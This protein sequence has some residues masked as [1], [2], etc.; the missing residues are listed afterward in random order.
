M[1]ELSKALSDIRR[2]RQQVAESTEFRGYGPA[3]VAGTGLLAAIAA[4]GQSKWLPDPGG[5]H[6]AF[7]GL[8]IGTAA[9][10]VAL[11]S[12]EMY[13]R[14][15]RMQSGMADAMIRT[16]AE[17]FLPAVAAG[18]LLTVA[19]MRYVPGSFW[20]LP[21]LWQVIFSLGV[22]ASCRF[23]PRPMIVAGA[24]YLITGLVLISLADDRAISPR[25]MGIPYGV[26]QTLVAMILLWGSKRREDA[27]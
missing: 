9:V 25:A 16:A 21:G 3:T 11:I 19:L 4:L 10:A 22:F 2:I 13:A 17:Q 5:H 8:W 18:I 27:I 24:W 1:D 15:R 14:T 7:L 23:L 26:G 12:C 20:M 6:S